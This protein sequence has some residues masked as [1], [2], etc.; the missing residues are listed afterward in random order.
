MERASRRSECRQGP[1][2]TLTGDKSAG[3]QQPYYYEGGQIKSEHYRKHTWTADHAQ[4]HVGGTM[5]PIQVTPRFSPFYVEFEEYLGGHNFGS[6]NCQLDFLN[7]KLD[8]TC[9]RA[10]ADVETGLSH[11]CRRQPVWPA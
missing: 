5:Q 11:P 3:Y 8:W 9:G 7:M 2:D 1:Q 6:G 4:N 10:G